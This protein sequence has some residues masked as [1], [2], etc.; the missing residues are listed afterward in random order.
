M[1][2]SEVRLPRGYFS[3]QLGDLNKVVPE[4]ETLEGWEEDI[5]Q[6]KEFSALPP[7]TQ[8][9]VLRIQELLGIPVSWIGLGQERMDMLRV[10]LRNIQTPIKRLSLSDLRKRAK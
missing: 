8:K 4:Y 6:C 10:D 5:S 2:M 1:D 9:Y 7:Q 3:A